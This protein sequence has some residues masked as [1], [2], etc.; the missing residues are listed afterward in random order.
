MRILHVGATLDPAY[1]GPPSAFC[2]LAAAHAALGHRV[3][4]LTTA[5]PQTL[6]VR[7]AIAR[8]IA[9][10]PQFDRVQRVE[11]VQAFG[12]KGV[13]CPKT[14]R[15]LITR[16]VNEAD[17][18]HIHEV[19]IPLLAHVAR[20][21]RRAGKP[22]AL[23][24]HGSLT[25]LAL[26]QKRLKKAIAWRA[27]GFRSML[28]RASVLTP[29]NP[30]EARAIADLGI[31]RPI[32]ILVNGVFPDELRPAPPRGV[33]RNSL[34]IGH[35]PMVLFLSRLHHGKGLELLAEAFATV[36]KDV[37]DAHLVCV[38][39]D[40][41]MKAPLQAQ[42]AALGFA[43]RLHTPGPIYG[44]DKLSAL[45]DADVFCLP[46]RSEGFSMS[47]TEAMAMG[48]PVVITQGCNF[49][50]AGEAGAG[51]VVPYQAPALAAALASYLLDP[52]AATI[53]G[54]AGQR[55]VHTRFTWEAVARTACRLYAQHGHITDDTPP[56]SVEPSAA[57]P[58]A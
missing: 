13:L 52:A 2:R 14:D 19:W 16:L 22:Y 21:A 55:L 34:G 24:T 33:F 28:H 25:P 11:A 15:Q 10:I 9:S 47:I 43:D 23:S 12:L 58:A 18:I 5:A 30:V 38:G 54:R 48:R 29:N 35:A 26:A 20:A 37:P 41:G 8:S 39:P 31:K 36:R 6:Q 7:E 50:L 27:L 1:G 57:P 40:D 3:T 45:V 53:A 17:V 42:A 51:I 32:D 4:L 49:P 44:R 56:A 46:S